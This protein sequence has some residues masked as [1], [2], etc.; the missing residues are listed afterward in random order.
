VTSLSP[1][2]IF[3]P[4]RLT[5]ALDIKPGSYPNSVSLSKKGVIP[6]A[7]L[8][9]PSFDATSVNPAS[10]CFGDAE[11]PA[12]RDCT[13]APGSVV[14]DVN[15]DGIPDLVLH[16]DTLQTGIDAG[17]TQACLSALLVDGTPVSGCDSIRVK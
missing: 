14:E 5:V 10:A 15:G 9:Q 17:D 8:G 12:E 11:S 6:V 7:V 4:G 13:V 16:F 2:A 3:T 1:F